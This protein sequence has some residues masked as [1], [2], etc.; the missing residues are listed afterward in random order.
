[1]LPGSLFLKPLLPVFEPSPQGPVVTQVRS[2]QRLG[3]HHPGRA[4]PGTHAWHAYVS[5]GSLAVEM[6]GG[7]AGWACPV[8]WALA[9]LYLT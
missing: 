3:V 2:P 6:R 1:M 9:D 5:V 7:L 8:F 4:R